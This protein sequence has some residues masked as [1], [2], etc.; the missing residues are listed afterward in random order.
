[1]SNRISF[2]V[3]LS[4]KNC[5]IMDIQADAVCCPT[6]TKGLMTDG[7]AL[8]IR[9]NGG[10]PIETEIMDTA[11]L[12]IGAA[13]V[14]TAGNLSNASHV[15]HVP[16][17]V[18]DGDSARIE[19]IRLSV[20]AALVACNHF[21]FETLV[22]PGPGPCAKLIT[23]KEI[24]RAMIDEIRNFRETPPMNVYLVDED[25]EM[26]RSWEGYAFPQK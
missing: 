12:A 24:A 8:Q 25:I 10:E 20:R 18:E 14:T 3:E 5:S 22:I 16:N 17:R 1:M 23:Q 6:S 2:V 26:V 4:F 13:A 9:E 15:I 19:H 11:P 21:K 7:P